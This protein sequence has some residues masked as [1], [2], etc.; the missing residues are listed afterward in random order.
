MQGIHRFQQA[1]LPADVD[2]LQCSGRGFHGLFV[3]RGDTPVGQH[4]RLRAGAKGAAGDGAH[5]TH[6]GDAVQHHEKR[7]LSFFHDERYDVLKFVIGHQRSDGDAPLVIGAA[8]PV[9]LFLRHRVDRY[10]LPV[11]EFTDRGD[12]LPAGGAKDENTLDGAP[13]PEGFH[14]RLTPDDERLLFRFHG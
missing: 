2:M 11:G 6:V 8:E 1:R 10:P 12:D 4:Q 14:D 5:V 9:E 13:R 7:C 3:Q